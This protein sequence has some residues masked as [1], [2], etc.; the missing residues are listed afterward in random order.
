MKEATQASGA[1][2][3]FDAFLV[4]CG[5]GALD[6]GFAEIGAENLDGDLRAFVAQELHQGDGM[7]VG[8]FARGTAGNPD[9]NGRTAASPRAENLRVDGLPQ[10]LERLRVAKKRSDVDQ[11]VLVE[12]IDFLAVPLEKRDVLAEVL[13]FVQDHAAPDPTP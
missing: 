2:I 4:H 10:S 9:A 8:L 12:S 13:D 5:A 1:H 6:S 3:G 11:Q 7:R